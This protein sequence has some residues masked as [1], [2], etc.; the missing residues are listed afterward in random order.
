M[1]RKL[2]ESLPP[3]QEDDRP[4]STVVGDSKNV[5][6]P[7]AGDGSWGARRSTENALG[8]PVEAMTV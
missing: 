3:L 2:R 7:A 1:V 6:H 8:H 4:T 5:D